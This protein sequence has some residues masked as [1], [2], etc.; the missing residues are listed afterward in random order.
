[1]ATVGQQLTSPESGWKRIDTTDILNKIKILQGNISTVTGLVAYYYNGTFLSVTG[2]PF[3]IRFK[4]TG[5]KIR[6]IMNKWSTLSNSVTV[7]IDNTTYPVFSTS[8]A[9]QGMSLVFEATGLPDGEHIIDISNGD[10]KGIEFD[11]IDVNES[12]VINEGTYV[13]GEQLTAPEAGWKRYDDTHPA[14]KYIGSGWNTE[15][16]LAHYNNIAHWSR[17]V[18]NKIKFKFKGTKIRIITDR[19]TNRLANSQSI[20][21]DGVKE[22]INTYGTVQGQTLSFEKTGLADTIHEVELQNETD[23]LQL[24][25]IDIDDTG[26]LLHPDE[27]T[28]IAD[29]DVGKRIRCHYQA[30]MSG[31]IGMFSGL[32]QETSDFIPPTSS[33]TPNGDFYWICCDIKN[34]KKIL[35]ADRNIQHSISWDKI[36]EQGMTNTGREITF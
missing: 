1:M 16:H 12:A 5:N 11:A 23:L 10:G 13:I 2:N 30:P 18:G 33:A 34:G 6:L 15:T 19:N 14:I 25:A 29:L 36:N 27:V 7:K 26:R 21:I 17:T 31:Q 22:Y 4:F 24:D 9:N 20:T 32:G 35:L 3:K 28:D 8:T